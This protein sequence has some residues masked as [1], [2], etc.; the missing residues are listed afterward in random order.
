MTKAPWIMSA[1][2]FSFAR[3]QE[4]GGRSSIAVSAGAV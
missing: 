3:E 2:A 4:V 1:A